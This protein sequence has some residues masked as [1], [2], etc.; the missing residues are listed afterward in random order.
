MGDASTPEAAAYTLATAKLQ[1]DGSVVVKVG[2]LEGHSLCD[3][4][5]K[6]EPTQSDY[7]FWR[8]IVESRFKAVVDSQGLEELHKRFEAQRSGASRDRL[9]GSR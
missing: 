7:G 3:G 6:V 4:F 2:W 5:R 8:W 1:A 9:R